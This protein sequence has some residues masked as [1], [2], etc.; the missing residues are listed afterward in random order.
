MLITNV[1]SF[2]FIDPATTVYYTLSLHDALPILF[3]SEAKSSERP[4][5]SVKAEESAVRKQ[6]GPARQSQPTRP[7]YWIQVGAFQTVEAAIEL[8]K[9]FRHDGA[10][11]SKSWLTNAAGKR[12]GVWA[13]VRVRPFADRSQ[14]LPN[15]RDLRSRRS[16]A[17]TPEDP[18]YPPPPPPRFRDDRTPAP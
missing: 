9:R 14:A 3:P 10:T 7:S 5:T 17:L 1:T 15:R 11:I 4:R 6:V 16:T 13:R 2:F 8:A 18:Q 12:V